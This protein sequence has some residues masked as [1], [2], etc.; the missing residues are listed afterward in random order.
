MFSIYEH[1]Y[2]IVFMVYPQVITMAIHGYP[3]LVGLCLVGLDSASLGLLH[4]GGHDVGF[5][6]R[7]SMRSS[8]FGDDLPSGYLT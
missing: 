8:P 6:Q 3:W 4:R 2:I 5:T 7:G 1:T